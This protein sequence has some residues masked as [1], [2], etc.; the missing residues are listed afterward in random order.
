VSTSVSQ[1]S[2]PCSR[3]R[4][5]RR[6]RAAPVFVAREDADGVPGGRVVLD[7]VEVAGKSADIHCLGRHDLHIDGC[8]GRAEDVDPCGQL[9]GRVGG[10]AVDTA[11]VRLVPGGHGVDRYP[12]GLRVLHPSNES[13][14]QAL[15]VRE[16]GHAAGAAVGVGLGGG[17]AAAGSAVGTCPPRRHP[18]RDAVLS[19]RLG[20]REPVAIADPEQRQA[21]ALRGGPEIVSIRG[22]RVAPCPGGGHAET[23]DL[24]LQAGQAHGHVAA[25]RGAAGCNAVGLM[26][27]PAPPVPPVP[28]PPVAPPTAPPVPARRRL[29]RVG[30]PRRRRGP[31][32]RPH[33]PDRRLRR[34]YL[35]S[36][37]RWRPRHRRRD[38]SRRSRPCRRPCHHLRPRR[39]YPPGP[40]PSAPPAPPPRPAVPLPSITEP[41]S[42]D[43]AR[44]ANRGEENPARGTTE[45]HEAS[46]AQARSA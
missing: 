3:Y 31:H 11:A 45:R 18:H 9:R 17:V 14:G 12:L 44:M 32:F 24:L 46:F 38:H 41:A 37:H 40:P 25:L 19:S 39:R 34:R 21:S 16:H 2:L 23:G 33:R 7:R 30:C 27:P 36:R 28:A 42:H 22:V 26:T 8:H 6:Q 29:L 4:R 20:N 15:R 35:R 1:Y 43:A 13:A 10:R 5:L